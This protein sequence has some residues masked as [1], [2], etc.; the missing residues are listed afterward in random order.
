MAEPTMTA[1]AVTTAAATGAASGITLGT[2]WPQPDIALLSGV[3]CGALVFLLRSKEPSRWK[4]GVYFIVSLAG[5]Y[6]IAPHLRAAFAWMPIWLAAFSTAAALVAVAAIA[7]D[8]L[9]ARLG[10]VLGQ[11]IDQA[12]TFISG[13]QRHD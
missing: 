6:Y 5:G 4:K 1:G 7:L 2:L 10:G 11:L 12:V 8:I 3:F 13:K 9:E